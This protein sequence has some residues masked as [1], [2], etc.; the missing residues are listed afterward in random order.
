[1]K[2][3]DERRKERDMTTDEEVAL[4]LLQFLFLK[5]LD[6][7]KRPV[8]FLKLG[9]IGWRNNGNGNCKYTVDYSVFVYRWHTE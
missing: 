3:Q 8:K 5:V 2:E 9:L 4:P 6:P 1:V 7:H